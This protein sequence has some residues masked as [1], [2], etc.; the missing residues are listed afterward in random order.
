MKKL[1]CWRCKAEI[2]M[3]E[4]DEFKLVLEANSK[5]MKFVEQQIR[6]RGIKDYKFLKLNS[7]VAEHKRAFPE[8]YQILTGFDETNPNAV[9]HHQVDLY[10]P[11]CPR[12]HKPL[13]TNKARHC[14]NCGFGKEDLVDDLRPLI[15]RKPE[16]F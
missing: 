4:T 16:L 11:P 1:W 8:M 5:G 13:R 9:W 12:C 6:Q 10:G 14:V 2:P 3:L 15:E 7:P